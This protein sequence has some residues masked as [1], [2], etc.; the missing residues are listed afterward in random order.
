MKN[1]FYLGFVLFAV[2]CASENPSPALEEKIATK[3]VVAEETNKH[4]VSAHY[5]ENEKDTLL[6]D[7]ASYIYRK[8]ASATWETKLDPKFRNY[9]IR[10]TAKFK[11][12]YYHIDEDNTHYY[13]LSRPARDHEG[14][15]RRGVGGMFKRNE[16]NE[17]V[18]FEEVF[19][20]PIH[21]EEKLKEIGLTLF[22][23][24]IAH[25]NVDN[26]LTD[27]NLIE[28]PDGR[29]FYSKEKKEWRYVD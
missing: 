7:L 29:L 8:P 23:E 21:P 16:K 24:M 17:I 18:D 22:E 9:Y 14:K 19:N 28:W 1:I 6:V 10:N 3:E 20:T 11:I 26:Y 25:R 2:G 15:Q 4:P 5:T 27:Q 13:Y 12:I